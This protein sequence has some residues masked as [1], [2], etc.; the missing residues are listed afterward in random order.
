[1]SIQQKS[2]III[3]DQIMKKCNHLIIFTNDINID[4]Q[5]E[6]FA[7]TII[8]S[9]S[10]IISIMMNKKQIYLK[11][12][13]EITIYSEEMMKFDLALNITKNHSWNRL[14]V[15]FT[16]FQTIIQVIQCLKKQ[17]NQYL[18][19]TLARRV[20][21][22]DKEILFTEFSFMLKFSTMKQSI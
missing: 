19:Q 16:N 10:N 3:H 5:V 13:I 21:Q 4:N 2:A 20:E 22:C 7:M 14:I 18:L 6:A 1:M 9:T 11:S 12:I 8:F 15:I 17:S